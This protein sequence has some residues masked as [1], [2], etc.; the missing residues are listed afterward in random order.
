MNLMEMACVARCI[1]EDEPTRIPNQEFD[2]NTPHVPRP[3]R[4]VEEVRLNAADHKDR[5]CSVTPQHKP[6]SQD[7]K[8]YRFGGVWVAARVCGGG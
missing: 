1:C 5:H 8:C 3:G 7:D 2:T 6:R 4:F